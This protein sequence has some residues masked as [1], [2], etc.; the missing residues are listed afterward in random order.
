MAAITDAKLQAVPPLII[1][2]GSLTD[3]GMSLSS[4]GSATA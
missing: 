3:R 1:A 4:D 2:P